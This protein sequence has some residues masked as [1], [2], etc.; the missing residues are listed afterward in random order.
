MVDQNPY[1]AP[2][3]PGPT[4]PTAPA[5][6]EAVDAPTAPLSVPASA[7][8]PRGGD[9]YEVRFI[10]DPL[11]VEALIPEEAADKAMMYLFGRRVVPGVE[12][13]A[14]LVDPAPAPPHVVDPSEVYAG[15]PPGTVHD[16][17]DAA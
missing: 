9:V 14:I 4:E 10:A 13:H 2:A 7:D 16:G 11:R 17:L 6:G 1:A 3:G 15:P 5:S 8:Q 12:A